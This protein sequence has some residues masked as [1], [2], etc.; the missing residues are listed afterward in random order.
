LVAAHA[1]DQK[2]KNCKILPGLDDPSEGVEIAFLIGPA[3]DKRDVDPH[4]SPDTGDLTV[5]IHLFG[6]GAR[7]H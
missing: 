1:V 5:V 2:S 7:H 6:G 3:E 4:V